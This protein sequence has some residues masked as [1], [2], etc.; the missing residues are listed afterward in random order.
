MPWYTTDDARIDAERQQ[1]RSLDKAQP[2]KQ[3]T[4]QQSGPSDAQMLY[5]LAGLDQVS[6]AT[7]EASLDKMILEKAK[8]LIAEARL[9]PLRDAL[10]NMQQRMER[11]D[12]ELGEL[13]E[14]ASKRIQEDSNHG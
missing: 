4:A 14:S 8:A 11:F 7:L 12:W 5:V 13:L 1:A 10:D 3:V 9:E 2:S 6:W